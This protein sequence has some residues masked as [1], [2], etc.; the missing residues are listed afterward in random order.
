MGRLR[1][2][3]YRSLCVDFKD[4]VLIKTCKFDCPPGRT[5]QRCVSSKL[6]RQRVTDAYSFEERYESFSD[7]ELKQLCPA[8][9]DNM[10]YDVDRRLCISTNPGL[11]CPPD[12]KKVDATAYSDFT[13]T[14]CEIGTFSDDFDAFQCEA[15]PAGTI[16][17]EDGPDVCD[18]T[19]ENMVQ[20]VHAWIVQSA[21]Q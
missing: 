4:T 16:P 13:C 19:V 6:N 21:I 3:Q 20:R 2:E 17:K 11:R 10:Y 12:Q 8:C 18:A 7:A 15:C 5:C 9:P 1:I 14:D